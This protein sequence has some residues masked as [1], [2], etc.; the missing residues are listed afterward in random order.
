M[1]ASLRRLDLLSSVLIVASL[2]PVVSASSETAA[3][4]VSAAQ[5]F[6]RGVYGCDASVVRDVASS[7]VIVSYPVFEKLFGKSAFR[8]VEAVESFAQGFCERWASAEFTFHESLTNEQNVVLIWSFSAQRTA[9]PAQ[10]SRTS[11]GGISLFRFNDNGQITAEVGEEST[12]G[13][14]AR[15]KE[16]LE[17]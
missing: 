15:L 5:R 12:P 16:A 6:F 9:D 11:W 7:D 2:T 1:A 14:M 8:G 3:R 17:Q 10:T 13:P 4:R